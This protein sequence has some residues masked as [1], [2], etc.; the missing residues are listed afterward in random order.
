MAILRSIGVVNTGKVKFQRGV[1][2]ASHK[3]RVLEYRLAVGFN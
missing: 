1:M 3:E 2:K